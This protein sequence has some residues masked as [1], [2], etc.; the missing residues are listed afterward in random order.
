MLRFRLESKI[1]TQIVFHPFSIWDRRKP[2]KRA[3]IEPFFKIRRL[4]DVGSRTGDGS[5]HNLDSTVAL[6]TCRQISAIRKI[7]GNA[8]RIENTNLRRY[9]KYVPTRHRSTRATL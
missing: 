3:K 6:P 4:G 8:A 1:P 7:L 5:K 2:Q 9:G